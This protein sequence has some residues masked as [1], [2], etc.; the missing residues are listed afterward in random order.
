MNSIIFDK[1]VVLNTYFQKILFL[2]VT[3]YKTLSTR[4]FLFE[5]TVGYDLY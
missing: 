3:T 4:I 5:I 1:N 2:T